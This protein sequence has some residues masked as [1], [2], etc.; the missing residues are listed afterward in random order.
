M[1]PGE[2]LAIQW[3]DVSPDATVIE[4]QRRVYRGKVAKMKFRANRS[5]RDVEAEVNLWVRS[6]DN[7]DL[8][9]EE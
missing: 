5:L 3:K 7:V 8:D 6:F 4:I 2:H 9:E 1:R